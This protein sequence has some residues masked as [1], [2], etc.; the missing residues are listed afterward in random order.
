MKRDKTDDNSANHAADLTIDDGQ[1]AQLSA[2]DADAVDA[3]FANGFDAADRAQDQS[4]QQG[5]AAS[6]LGL[7][8]HYPVP[9][10]PENLAKRTAAFVRQSEARDR[11]SM[12]IQ[13]HAVP[14]GTPFR[15]SE[16][17][18][19]AA[20]FLVGASVVWP[21]LERTRTDARQVACRANLH[22]AAVAF[23]SYASEHNGRLPRG[24]V[25]PDSPWYKVGHHHE[26]DGS[27]RSN[28][29]HLFLLARGGYVNPDK[30]N[31]PEN[32]NAL[33]NLSAT[34]HDWPTPRMSSLPRLG[35]KALPKARC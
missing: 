22:D 9:T 7:L 10:P 6:L 5:R 2:K 19:V 15:W 24:M 14:M 4:D 8:N 29:A 33:D 27:V 16:L 28:T 13:E 35:A 34:R 1:F 20:I 12:Q 11:R 32:E 30:L 17:I 3:L 18:A 23:T 31:C 26:G 25:R 21:V